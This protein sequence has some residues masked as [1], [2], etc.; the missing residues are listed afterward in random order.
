MDSIE[1]YR[2]AVSIWLFVVAA[3]VFSMIIVGGL[4]RLQN[5][6]LSMVNWRPLVG[7]IPP[8][9][10]AEWQEVFAKYREFPEYQQ[11]NSVKGMSLTEFKFIF[12]FEYSHRVLGRLIGS[13]F[14]LP[15]LFFW[16]KKAF[17]KSMTPKMVLLFILGGAQGVIGWWMVKSGLV[18]RPDVSHYRL[19]VHLGMAVALYIALLWIGIS[20]WKGKGKSSHHKG[21]PFALILLGLVFL[22]LLSGGLVAGLNAGHMM[23]TFP[24]MNGEWIPRG[25]YR[26]DLGFWNLTENQ[27]MLQFNHRYL[28]LTTAGL[29]IWFWFWLK[30]Q[31]LT[32]LQK[33]ASLFAL[34]AVCLQVSLGI[35]TLLTVVWVPVASMHQAGAVLLL[36]SLVWLNI[37][38]RNS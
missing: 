12:F 1:K 18:D 6:G 34:L 2:R 25:L 14:A 38:L 17:P 11:I 36:S 28:A 15:A 9:S 35:T 31:E 3:M 7:I 26:L 10:E 19:T 30:K 20:H 22:V 32:P 29:I 8:L 37:E 27:I 16:F 5:A 33:R 24:L 4:T 23:N 13:V 21:A